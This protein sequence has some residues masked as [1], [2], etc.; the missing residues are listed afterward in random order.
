[1]MRV[2][3]RG[4]AGSFTQSDD[5][6][7]RRRASRAQCRERMKKYRFNDPSKQTTL[8]RYRPYILLFL[9]WNLIGVLGWKFATFQAKDNDPTWDSKS[10]A[11]RIVSVYGGQAIRHKITIGKRSEDETGT[12]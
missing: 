11:E 9:G 7:N 2:K 10:E 6:R 12:S 1:M 3:G 4:L 8:Q 5:D